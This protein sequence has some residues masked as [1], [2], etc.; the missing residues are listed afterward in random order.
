VVLETG[1]SFFFAGDYVAISPRAKCL[2]Q[3]LLLRPALEAH[4]KSHIDKRRKVKDE[5][6]ARLASVFKNVVM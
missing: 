2:A 6:Y 4:F 5:Y 1:S 3:V